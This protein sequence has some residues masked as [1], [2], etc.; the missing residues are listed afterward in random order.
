MC[1]AS[2]RS[3]PLVFGAN[4]SKPFLCFAAPSPLWPCRH[5]TEQRLF[6]PNDWL[7]TL[8]E[9]GFENAEHES[10]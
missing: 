6:S 8:A 1:Q 3:K 10:C 7:Q 4:R 9:K 5:H 2:G